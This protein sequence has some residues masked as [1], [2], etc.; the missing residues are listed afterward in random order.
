MT[1]VIAQAST[2]AEIEAAVS[3][4]MSVDIGADCEM[5][6]VEKAGG[7]IKK[8]LQ[9]AKTT[10]C[11]AIGLWSRSIV[12]HLYF[13]VQRGGGNGDL[14]VAVWLSITNHV[15]DKHHGHSS[16]YDRC[17]HGDLEPRKG[18]FPGT[19]AF[20]KLFS[21]ITNKR[22]LEDIRQMS[23][24]FQTFSVEFFDAII[25][26]FAPKAYAYSFHG[27]FAR[28]VLAALH[29]N[30]NADKGQAVTT[31]GE[32]RWKVKYP[33]ARKGEATASFVK[34]EPTY[35]YVDRLFDILNEYIDGAIPFA[36]PA[37]PPHVTSALGPI[38]K[39]ELVQSHLSRF[40]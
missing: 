11:T 19:Q 9:A 15:Q 4:P 22:L 27:I 18:I 33:K 14:A 40:Q 37:K 2:D 28:T 23:P 13:A 39:T 1:P 16:L 38:D 17:Q 20:D 30:E 5:N 12:N 21:I 25:N 34:Q 32:L 31:S 6:E 10:S 7:V 35:G 36:L 3:P 24:H 26:R 29:D 8:L